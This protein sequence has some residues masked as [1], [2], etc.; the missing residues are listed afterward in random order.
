MHRLTGSQDIVFGLP[1]MNRTGSGALSV[2]STVMNVVPLHLQ[3]QEGHSFTALIQQ[4]ASRM[5]EIRKHQSYRHEELRRDLKLN[6]K[7][8]NLYGPII[9]IMPFE[10]TLKWGGERQALF[11]IWLL[12]L[13]RI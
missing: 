5:R 4:T 1:M 11:T 6:L 2:P 8:Q 3:L 13:W 12:D 7:A 9:N 10:S